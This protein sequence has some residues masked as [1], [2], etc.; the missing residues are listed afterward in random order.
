MVI[1]KW[2]KM[3]TRNVG[4]QDLRQEVMAESVC[5][6]KCDL[7][8]AAGPERLSMYLSGEAAPGVSLISNFIKGELQG[9]LPVQQLS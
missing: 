8:L 3:L 1:K 2:T 9:R 7:S 5:R 4:L 6:M